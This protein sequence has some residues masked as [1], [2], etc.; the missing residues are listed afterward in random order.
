M[1]APTSSFLKQL[2]DFA[3]LIVFYV[4]GT[5]YADRLGGSNGD[6]AWRGLVTIVVLIDQTLFH[7]FFKLPCTDVR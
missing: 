7:T 2:V 4:V 1:A 5:M 3:Q 6:G